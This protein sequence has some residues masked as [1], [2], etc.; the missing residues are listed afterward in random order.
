MLAWKLTLSWTPSMSTRGS[1]KKPVPERRKNS[2]M[3]MIGELCVCCVCVLSVLCVSVWLGWDACVE[4]YEESTFTIFYTVANFICRQPSYYCFVTHML[5]LSLNLLSLVH[6]L[7]GH[8]YFPPL[9]LHKFKASVS[10]PRSLREGRERDKDRGRE[11]DRDRE[12][13]EY[14]GVSEVDTYPYGGNLTAP[15]VRE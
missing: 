15:K 5:P 9:S 4:V 2:Q 7:H 3:F 13:E 10:D 8:Y 12:R 6:Y 14:D 11:R 1:C